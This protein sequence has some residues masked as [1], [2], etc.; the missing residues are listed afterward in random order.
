MVK[1]DDIEEQYIQHFYFAMSEDVQE[2]SFYAW[3]Y[4]RGIIIEV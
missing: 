4:L 1:W 2:D 3:S